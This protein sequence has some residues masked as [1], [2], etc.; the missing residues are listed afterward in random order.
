MHNNGF[1]YWNQ[2]RGLDNG[3]EFNVDLSL[4]KTDFKLEPLEQYG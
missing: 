4:L 1:Q 3:H 2:S